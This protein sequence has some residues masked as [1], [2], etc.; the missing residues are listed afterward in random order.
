L[1]NWFEELSHYAQGIVAAAAIVSFVAVVV[2][3]VLG[4]K[5]LTHGNESE[6]TPVA[7]VR[8]STPAPTP[9]A[10]VLPAQTPSPASPTATPPPVQLPA[11]ATPTPPPPTCPASDATGTGPAFPKSFTV[12][13][14]CIAVIDAYRVND[15]MMVV[16]TTFQ[17][18]TYN[19]VIQDGQITYGA[20]AQ[21]CFVFNERIRSLQSRNITI[22]HRDTPP[23]C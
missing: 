12:P 6:P 2:G 1:K 11:T 4:A 10:T 14:G 16:V 17:S 20:A 21:L 3:G 5:E 18:G 15:R 7:S 9:L 22:T 23:G 19:V 13:P 8:P